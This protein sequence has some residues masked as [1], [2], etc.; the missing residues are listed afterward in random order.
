MKPFFP[1]ISIILSCSFLKASD[2]LALKSYEDAFLE[3]KTMLE[4][5]TD[6][7]FKRAVFI[8][9]NAYNKGELDYN[10]FSA[11]ISTITAKLKQFIKDRNLS[12]YK[13][14]GN[15]AVFAYMTDTVK[16]ND[17]QPYSYDFDD[18]MGDKDWRSMFVTKLMQTRKGNCH[19]LPYF[20]KIL[21]DEMNVEAFLAIAPNHV[22]IKHKDENR[23]WANIELTNGSFFRDQWMI[24]QMAVTVEA[25]KS[26]AYMNPLNETEMLAM[27]LFDLASG[28][29]YNYGYDDFFLE[30]VEEGLKYFPNSIELHMNK[31]NYYL[32]LAENLKQNNHPLEAQR[33][34]ELYQKITLRINELGHQELPLELYEEW[35]RSMEEEKKKQDL[36]GKN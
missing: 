23:Q 26:E 35:V 13:T 15:Y 22:Y 32:D 8:T 20:Y 24:E 17:F 21:C 28:Y 1:F 5:N 11:E 30:V 2:S 31:A 36:Q 29:Q 19:S 18:F 14:A 6:F 10:V 7:S 9:E 27:C 4:G 25:I 34:F 12:Q 16:E 33:I 3:I